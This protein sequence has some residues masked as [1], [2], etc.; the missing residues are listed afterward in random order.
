VTRPKDPWAPLDPHQ[1]GSS[2]SCKP[3]RKGR[4]SRLPAELKPAAAAAKRKAAAA[5][6]AS[7]GGSAKS[8]SAASSK[9]QE[10][11]A[12]VVVLYLPLAGLAFPEFRCVLLHSPAMLV[13]LQFG[14][15]YNV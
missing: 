7:S 1:P 8:G 3:W 5:A 10:A 4:T 11:A 13:Q 2:A 15:D 9:E 6:T 12:G 14:I